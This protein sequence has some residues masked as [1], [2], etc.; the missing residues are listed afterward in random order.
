MV[1]LISCRQAEGH[2][3][4]FFFFEKHGLF[5]IVCRSAK[6]IGIDRMKKIFK[7]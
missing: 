2:E 3:A 7:Y 6:R 5:F 4:M 1:N